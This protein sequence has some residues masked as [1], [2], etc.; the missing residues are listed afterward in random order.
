VNESVFGSIAR[1][2]IAWLVLIVI[3]VVALKVVFSVVAGFIATVLS[4]ALIALLVVGAFWAL[5]RI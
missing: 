2:A 3:A 1:R 5:R 4:L